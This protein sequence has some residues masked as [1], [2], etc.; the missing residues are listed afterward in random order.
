MRATGIQLQRDEE[1]K[2]IF[3][4]LIFFVCDARVTDMTCVR[5]SGSGALAR[6]PGCSA[7]RVAGDTRITMA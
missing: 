2:I 1:L 4:F 3:E 6:Q 7:S 5:K